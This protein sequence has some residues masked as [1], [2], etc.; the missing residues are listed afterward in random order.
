MG[1]EL[2]GGGGGGRGDSHV[3]QERRGIIP[4]NQG[5]VKALI[6]PKDTLLDRI[7]NYT[8]I[9]TLIVVRYCA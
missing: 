1:G 5:V 3:R 8:A 2:A 6:E 4:V 7:P 9:I